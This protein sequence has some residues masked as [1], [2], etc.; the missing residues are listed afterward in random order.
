MYI[1]NKKSI[2]IL[3]VVLLLLSAFLYHKSLTLF[4]AFMHSWTQSDRY[5]LAS[6]FL[7]NGFDFLH[8]KT[9]NWMVK[10]GI[11]RV[12]FPINEYIIALLMKIF[13]T[14]SFIVFRVYTL[15][16]SLTGLIYLFLLSKKITSSDIKA[17][18]IV[19]FVS[20]SPIYVYYQDGFIPTL[21]ALSFSF[22]AYYHFYSYQRDKT[23]KHFILSILFFTLAALIRMPF[24]IILIAA[25]LQQGFTY[26]KQRRFS[27]FEIVISIIG[28]G[29]FLLYFLYNV[30]LYRIYG[31]I[32]LDHLMP[33]KSVDE[34]MDVVSEMCKHWLLHYF[35]IGHYVLIL[36]LLC[37]GI[38]N[39]SKMKTTETNY[40][41]WRLHILLLFTGVTIY[42][43]LMARQYYAHD[44]YFLDSFFM[45]ILL[46]IIFSLKKSTI[47]NKKQII[48]YS[49]VGACF[50]GSFLYGAIKIQNERYAT[51][52]WDRTEITR[53]N[54][55]G[56]DK[57]LDDKGIPK[58]AK[59]LVIDAYTYN[60]PLILM[61][62]NGYTVLSTSY[63]EMSTSLF[64]CK[65]DYV[66][67]QDNYLVSDVIKNYPLI[68][69][70]LE[71]I[72]GT[73]KVSF[74]KRSSNMKAKSLKEFLAIS[75]ENTMYTAAINFDEPIKDT[76]HIKGCG[77]TTTDNFYSA[78]ASGFMDSTLE[79]GTTLTIK[80]KELKNSTNLKVLINAAVWSNQKFNNVQ[81][82]ASVTNTKATVFYQ[83]FNLSDYVK[84]LEKWQN[85]EFQ[86]VLPAFTTADDEL[87]IYLWNPKKVVVNYDDW[88]MVIYK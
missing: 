29:I 21:P 88:E 69:S 17:M 52:P 63:K 83:N 44:Y 13:G 26:I 51:G 20:L 78:P 50:I 77:H 58:D 81:I 60:V 76:I 36:I 80:A 65:W 70:L 87:K 67:L 47:E 15:L 49:T 45:P 35:T 79:Y 85:I 61:R 25:L 28:G 74:Y 82:V 9:F 32:F 24:V 30:H 18:F 37:F 56:T 66:A 2:P 41:P 27:F 72:G 53:Q 11:T 39:F 42:F 7:N 55:I 5:A 43:I 59:I 46:S 62:R 54:F 57:F 12:D 6:G 10:D 40:N 4:P 75:P 16:L 68:T 23:K 38:F 19:L 71:R 48:I 22:I 84:P 1:S 64:W 8:P 86:F 14:T 31:S 34:L 33:P 73:G 3:I